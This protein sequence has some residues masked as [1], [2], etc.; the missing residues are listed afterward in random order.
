MV[1][2]TCTKSPLQPNQ[3][4]AEAANWPCVTLSWSSQAAMHS[5][6]V[7]L[8]VLTLTCIDQGLRACCSATASHAA[9]QGTTLKSTMCEI[10]LTH[11]K[12]AK[13]SKKKLPRSTG[14]A[15]LKLLC[16]RLFKVPADSVLLLLKNEQSGMEEA[17]SQDDTKTLAYFDIEVTPVLCS[18]CGCL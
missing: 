8:N 12:T 18:S 4:P 3:E 11:P 13:S 7:S 2:P 16:A 9:N 14:I 15:T 17:M 6:G 1:P 10:T 5:H